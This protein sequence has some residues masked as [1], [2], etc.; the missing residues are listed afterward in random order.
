[1]VPGDVGNNITVYLFL[2]VAEIEGGLY[3]HALVILK[4]I[5]TI[6]TAECALLLVVFITTEMVTFVLGWRAGVTTGAGRAFL[7]LLLTGMSQ[8]KNLRV[9]LFDTD[10]KKCFCGQ[11]P[12]G[13][14]LVILTGSLTFTV[15]L[16]YC[17]RPHPLSTREW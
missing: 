7:F 6:L 15:L 1:M 8:T 9:L 12:S 17:R 13:F 2:V 16:I 5:T 3:I 10:L 11:V 14:Y 4:N